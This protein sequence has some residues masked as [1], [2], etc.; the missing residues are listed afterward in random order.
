MVKKK[1][2]AFV[3]ARYDSMRM[4]GKVC[5]K[6][7][8][9]LSALEILLE[10]LKKSKKIYE[11]IVLTSRNNNKEII[12]ICKKSKIK[13]FIGSEKNVLDRY[14]KAAKKYKA[15]HIL[16]ITADCP[17]TDISIVNKVIDT[18]SKNNFDYVSNVN[19]PTFP[20]GLD[21]ELFN[22]K[23]LQS[24][25]R[26]VFDNFQ[27]EHITQYIL[28]NNS[29]K[30]KNIISDTNY[31]NER[32]TLD[33][34]KDLILLR[35]IF[36]SLKPNIFF[37]WKNV[38]GLMKKNRSKFNI[39]KSYDRNFGMKINKNQMLWSRAKK[40]I[41]GGNHLFS[42][43][44]E[45]FLP[46]KW[47]TY[48]SKA[49]GC[50]IWD[51]ENKKYTD[52]SLMGVGTNILG[53][54]NNVV[55]QAV[56]KN[57]KKSN[58]STLNS[59]HEVELAEKLIKMHPW[60][61]MVRFTRS[62]GE[63][64]A[65]AIRIA[66]AASGKDKV[67]VCGYHGWHDWYLS[68]NIQNNKNLDNLLMKN[69]HNLGVPKKLK[70]TVFP[71]R[72]NDFNG[73][74]KII[75]KNDIGIIKMEVMRNEKPKNNFLQKVQNLAKKKNII[76]IF[77]E[78]TSGFRETFGGLHI[79][80]KVYPDMMILGKALGN[81]YAINAILGKKMIMDATHNTFISSTFWTERSG[82]VAALQTLKVMENI[83]SWKIIS[84]TGKSIKK[85][86][87][88]IAKKNKIDIK[89]SGIESLPS[90]QINHPNWMKFKTYI[91]Q[92]MLKK[93]ILAGNSI[94]VSI[95]HEKKILIKYYKHLDKIFKKI[96]KCIDGKNN[97][98]NIL[99]NEVCASDFFRLN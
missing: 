77:D 78:C 94:Y 40:I 53:Y 55:D 82:P 34:K 32:W 99:E 91:T 3:Q 28:K 46:N 68:A 2:F 37:S 45:M 33:T 8:S 14:Y 90:F 73:L 93:R 54:S 52:L 41:A 10:R 31:S 35:Y 60:F 22:F 21:I 4:P 64:N 47:P 1:F 67:A 18:Y 58:L 79:K 57:L 44:P 43:R 36:N 86:W 71:F 62:G 38:L 7:T 97:I 11:I 75:E 88:K 30:K 56:I 72:Y 20:D 42:K 76:L 29:F 23:S 69:L 70:N 26:N 65:V 96:K 80:E 51:L 84:K 25:W 83:K 61:D 87:T 89:I 59:F 15:K 19:P 48:Y 63:A 81:G 27:K 95:D 92:E 9:Q 50:F 16:R 66:R 17:L 13:F 49:K 5:K 39:N 24:S 98:N 85:N 74:K 6:L 12:K